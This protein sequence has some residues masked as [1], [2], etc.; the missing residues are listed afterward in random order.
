M[1]TP[2]P[3]PLV[4]TSLS[5]PDPMEPESESSE[6]GSIERS[7]SDD[8]PLLNPTSTK[9]KLTLFVVLLCGVS[10]I[11]GFLFGYD[12]GV[13]SGALIKL[14]VCSLNGSFNFYHFT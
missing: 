4:T 13:V 3:D 8:V 9:P 5:Y 11:G 6:T 12:T 10:T 7:L 1:S 14:K 2:S